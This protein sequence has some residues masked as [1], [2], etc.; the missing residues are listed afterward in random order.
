MREERL[1][2]FGF[3]GLNNCVREQHTQLEHEHKGVS[4]NA[5]LENRMA[6]LENTLHELKAQ[7]T[8]KTAGDESSG[9]AIAN[10]T[11]IML[12]QSLVQK[13]EEL[14]KKKDQ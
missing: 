7:T 5:K 6:A 2:G 9:V 4:I 14:S 10:A 8:K 13:V 11:T 1:K 3:G 12:L